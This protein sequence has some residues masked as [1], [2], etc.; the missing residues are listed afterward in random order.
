MTSKGPFQPKAFYDSMIQLEEFHLID[1]VVY[2]LRCTVV[3]LEQL[4]QILHTHLSNSRAPQL[5][6]VF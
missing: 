3:S 4:H 6:Y 2:Y 1:D 5:V